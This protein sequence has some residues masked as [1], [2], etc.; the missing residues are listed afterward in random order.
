MR[1]PS[2]SF[3]VAKNR[4]E[5]SWRPSALNCVKEAKETEVAEAAAGER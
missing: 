1:S 4:R 5:G 3:E 2:V